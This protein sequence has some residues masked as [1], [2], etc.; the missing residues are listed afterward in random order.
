MQ[1]LNT[2]EI[3]RI[4][5]SF[6]RLWPVS[7]R[8]ADLFYA[9]LFETAPHVRSL[10]RQD[11]DEQKRKFMSTLAV[12]VGTLDDASRLVPL[13]DALAQQHRDY[14]VRAAYYDVVG[15]A[16]LWSLEQGLG[17]EWTP[18]VADSWKKAYAIVSGH[19][20]EHTRTM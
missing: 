7:A 14:G 16:L 10:F 9:R 19:M 13:M 17:E 20:I 15:K 5:D 8:T 12:I 6:D 3:D 2:D 11:M 4:R 18:S 1:G